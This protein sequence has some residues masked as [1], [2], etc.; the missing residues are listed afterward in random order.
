MIKAAG[1]CK[2]QEALN[3]ISRI[4]NNTLASENVDLII[5]EDMIVLA[6]DLLECEK[7]FKYKV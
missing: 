4:P 3:V 7:E 2:R 1:G 6:N 5:Y